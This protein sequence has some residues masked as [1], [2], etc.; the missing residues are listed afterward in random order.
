[1]K[2]IQPIVDLNA[3]EAFPVA[4]QNKPDQVTIYYRR[5]IT[6]TTGGGL[7][8]RTI[9]G[10][11]EAPVISEPFLIHSEIENISGVSGG[12]LD[13][14]TFVIFYVVTHVAGTRDIWIIKGDSDNNFETPIILD[15]TNVLKLTGGYFYGPLIKGDNPGEYYHII[16]QTATSRYRVSIVK[17]TD[18]W[19]THSE[20]GVLYDGTIP[21]SETAG[22]N[23]GGGK[24]LAISRVNNA[25]SL[26]P[27]ESTNYGLTWLR[28]PA[29]N[30]YWWNGGGPEI[31]NICKRS[32]GTFDIFY[33]CRDTSMMQISKGNTVTDNFGK[34]TPIYNSPEIYC[35]HRGTGGNPSLGYGYEEELSSGKLFMIFSKEFTNTRANLMW[36]IDD[37]ISDS[38]IP[39]VPLLT[40]SGITATSFRF[41]ITNYGDWQNVRYCSMD[42]STM[43][44]F[45]GFVTCKYRAISAFPSVSINNI[46][47]TG[48]WDTFNGL[49]TGT[50]YYLRIKGVNNLGES[51]YTIKT[52]TTL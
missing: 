19:V 11:L 28:R 29:S 37:L 25:G 36:T 5:G 26:T 27:F 38:A 52:V 50:T 34:S 12:Q 30:L 17:T 35:Y 44:D 32:D 9:T 42:L 49:T 41:D 40:I 48:Y 3:Y 33:E 14:G 51:D 47:V 16:Y 13:D 45:S 1:M 2:N 43:S 21:Y 39:D 6:H 18:Y 20:I 46:R 31:P 23:L 8:G 10:L 15:W 4:W 7:F 22:I 24:M